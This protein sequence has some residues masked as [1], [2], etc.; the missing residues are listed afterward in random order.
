MDRPLSRNL[1]D[2]IRYGGVDYIE[3]ELGVGDCWSCDRTGPTGKLCLVCCYSLGV[4]LGDCSACGS[5][6]PIWEGCEYCGERHHGMHVPVY[7]GKCERCPTGMGPIGSRCDLCRMGNFV[8]AKQSERDVV[9]ARR[10][11]SG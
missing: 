4:V 5:S 2:L 10:L 3:G 6:G 1:V 8:I 7:F 11:M 9:A